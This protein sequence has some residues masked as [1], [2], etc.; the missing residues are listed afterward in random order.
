MSGIL[1]LLVQHGYVVLFGIILLENLGLPLPGFAV[2]ILAG[3]LAGAGQLSL[4]LVLPIAIVAALAGDLAWYGLGRWRGRPVLGFLCRLSLNPDTCVGN[5]E[6]FFLR[7]GMRTLLIAKFLPGVNTVTPP[8]LGILRGRLGPFLGY[9]FAGALIFSG[10]FVGVGYLLGWEIVHRAEA[11][12]SRMGA[13]FGWGAAGFGLAYIA[14]RLALRIRV[15]KALRAV[16][17]TP[18]ELRRWHEETASVVVIDVRTPLAVKE[19]PRLIAGALRAAQN[20]LDQLAE[21]LPRDRPIV[22]YCV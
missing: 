18:S 21:T 4:A 5:A 22:T 3:A 9:D 8:L 17:L 12:V 10:V 19:T 11:A 20:E 6:R 1:S 7:Q 16:A 2:L 15:R 14:W 13:L